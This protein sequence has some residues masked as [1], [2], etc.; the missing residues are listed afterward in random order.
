MVAVVRALRRHGLEAAVVLAFAAFC[1]AL[2]PPIDLSAPR[3]LEAAG[4][5]SAIALLAAVAFPYVS[6]R[7]SGPRH[8]VPLLVAC[9]VSLMAL[10]VALSA[11]YG[12]RTKYSVD[13]EGMNVVIGTDADLTA[14]GKLYREEIRAEPSDLIV[15][16]AGKPQLVWDAAALHSYARRMH[17][18]YFASEALAAVACVAFL[19]A[20]RAR[21]SRT[22][23]TQVP[24]TGTLER[25]E[26]GAGAEHARR[27]LIALSFP[28]EVRD[29]VEAIADELA[30][31]LGRERVFYDRWYGA[32]LARP[33]MDLHLQSIYKSQAELLVVVLCADYQRKEWCGLEWRVVREMIK[34]K[35]SSRIM[36]LRLDD[37][38]IEGLLSIDGYLDIAQLSAD[39]VAAEIMTRARTN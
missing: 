33:D 29:R 26:R 19:C 27:F 7:F 10:T 21:A 22:D 2:R 14:D 4:I 13:V 6:S 31:G 18:Y 5:A 24:T 1:F 11:Y 20:W 37:T 23:P 17:R 38:P 32:E 39:T 35:A 16:T 15:R 25:P 28:G 36:Y 9:A 8:W 3:S 12:L 30:S 34:V